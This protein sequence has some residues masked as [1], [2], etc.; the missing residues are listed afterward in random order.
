M[1]KIIKKYVPMTETAFYILLSLTEPRHGY[2]II[3]RV[4]EMT[5]GRLIL[6]SGTIYGTL[7]KMQ[8]DQVITIYS[9]EK[10]KTIY[11]ITSLGK[12]LMQVE[13]GRLKE[14]H[15]NVLRYEEDFK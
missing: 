8:R 11:E 10:R 7:T 6:G 13:M 4:E 9:D 3:K 12:E 1:N 2:G 5:E 14:L 15:A